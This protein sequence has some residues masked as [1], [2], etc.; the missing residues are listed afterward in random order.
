M[1]RGWAVAWEA[2]ACRAALRKAPALAS[3]ITGRGR[4]SV[5]LASRALSEHP[6]SLGLASPVHA[7]CSHV[8][9]SGRGGSMA[10][11]R[12]DSWITSRLGP[13]SPCVAYVER[14]PLRVLSASHASLQHLTLRRHRPLLPGSGHNS[15]A[16]MTKERRLACLRAS[17]QSLA[18]QMLEQAAEQ[19]RPLIT[20]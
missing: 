2:L 11:R 6:R 17:E 5:L 13:P 9:E 15:K 1:T 3:G 16:A 8:R 10:H 20:F 7:A 19:P 4:L 12:H 18:I 14:N